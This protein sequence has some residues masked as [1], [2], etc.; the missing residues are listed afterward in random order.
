VSP[1]GKIPFDPSAAP[2]ARA[3]F[4]RAVWRGCFLVLAEDEPTTTI[5][6]FVYG[7]PVLRA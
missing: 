5:V 2:D 4:A 6:F 3:P 7:R 1:R